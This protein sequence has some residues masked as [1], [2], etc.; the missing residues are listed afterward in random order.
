MKK[1]ITSLLSLTQETIVECEI[2]GIPLTISFPA[3]GIDFHYTSPFAEY[4]NIKKIAA[5]PS[6]E[7]HKLPKPILAGVLLGILNHHDLVEKVEITATE[8]NVF[9]QL[10]SIPV[11]LSAIKLFSSPFSSSL[12]AFF[13]KISLSS[14]REEVEY[15]T[16]TDIISSYCKTCK[17]IIN[18]A[19]SSSVAVVSTLPSY[20]KKIEVHSLTPELRREAKELVSELADDDFMTP[21]L[22]SI[23]KIVVQ[24]EN[25]VTLAD[26]MRAKLI[27]RLEAFETKESKRFIEILQYCDKNAHLSE[28]IKKNLIQEELSCK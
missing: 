8:A 12:L 13:P 28:K 23:L 21:K 11:M 16:A 4:K 27:T 19:P 1:S 24:K 7:L 2:T 14:L 5:L 22:L 25:L 17:E 3:C 26:E 10:V 6:Q 9:L 20:V 18:P 15:S